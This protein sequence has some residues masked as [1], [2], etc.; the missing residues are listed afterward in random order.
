VAYFG[1]EM[2]YF[3]ER[4]LASPRRD[5]ILDAAVEALRR[6]EGVG[7]AGRRDRL[8]GGCDARPH[9][10]AA[11]CRSLD[12]QRS[13]E[14]YVMPAE[15]A[16][17]DNKDDDLTVHGSAHAHDTTV[18]V[19]VWGPGIRAEVRPEIVVPRRVAAT[20]AWLLGV[21]PPDKALLPSL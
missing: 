14:L 10:D 11:V 5:E 2:I 17:F 21:P 12:A 16:I 15:D 4:A 1:Q 18:P 9:P 13:G 3:T 6:V 7:F 20:L 19:I 8:A